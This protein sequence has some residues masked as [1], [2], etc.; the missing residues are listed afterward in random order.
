MDRYRRG[1]E[2]NHEL[3]PDALYDYDDDY[4]SPGEDDHDDADTDRIPPSGYPAEEPGVNISLEIDADGNEVWRAED[5]R[6]PGSSSLGSSAEEAIEGVEDRRREY[7]E[8]LRR[9]KVRRRPKRR[10]S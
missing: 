7:R 3:E 5:S 2:D 1:Y 6:I 4:E 10:E 8:M 9:S